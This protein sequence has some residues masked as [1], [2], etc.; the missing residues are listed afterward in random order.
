MYRDYYLMNSFA[1]MGP[2]DLK[3]LYDLQGLYSAD[4]SLVFWR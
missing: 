1:Q 2:H 4:V 3:D